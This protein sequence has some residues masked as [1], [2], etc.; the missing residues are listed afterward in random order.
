MPCLQALLA[1]VGIEHI[2]SNTTVLKREK[3]QEII[4]MFYNNPV[5][6]N[7]HWKGDQGCHAVNTSHF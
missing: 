4:Y 6:T 3:H 5:R 7:H 1:P 2:H